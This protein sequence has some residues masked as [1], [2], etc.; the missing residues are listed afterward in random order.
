VHSRS[1][2]IDGLGRP[3][4]LVHGGEPL[5]ILLGNYGNRCLREAW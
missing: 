4:V 3:V 2:N 1:F 5:K